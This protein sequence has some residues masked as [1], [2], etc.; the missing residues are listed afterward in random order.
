MPR[1]KGSKNK[2]KAVEMEQP[3]E[4]DYERDDTAFDGAYQ[5]TGITSAEARPELRLGEAVT[6]VRPNTM[7][8]LG[9][10]TLIQTIP[11]YSSTPVLYLVEG[12]VQLSPRI[13]GRGSMVAKQTR[14]VRATSD[15]QA[16]EKY[17]NYFR[18]LGDAEASYVVLRA[19]AM[20]I[21]E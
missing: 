12:D 11:A 1:P 14:L 17:S 13:P 18:N 9:I 3:R 19:A 21:I 6:D 20:E 2:E 15:F 7:P 4:F 8:D 5:A 16:V 10:Q